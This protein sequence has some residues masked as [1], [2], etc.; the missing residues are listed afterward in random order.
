MRALSVVVLTALLTALLTV[1][2]VLASVSAA[3]A[4]TCVKPIVHRGVHNATI[5]EDTVEA[6]LASAPYGSAEIDIHVNADD[7]LVV[8]HDAT[9]DRTTDGT[10]YVSDLTLGQVRELRTTPNGSM[11]PTLRQALRAAAQVD[12]RILVELK[13]ASQWTQPLYERVNRFWHRFTARG[14]TIYV[15]GKG[16]AF[17]TRIPQWA[18]DVLVYWRPTD[19]EVP[20]VARA[21]ALGA[22]MV[23]DHLPRWSVDRVSL[24]EA[25]GFV[26]ASRVTDRLRRA[27]QLGLDFA[28][29]KHLDGA[30][31]RNR[32]SCAYVGGG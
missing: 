29:T 17:E 2:S 1:G 10:G 14:A 5:D 16:T 28:M 32:G 13:Q 12:L 15:G 18:P 26:T 4:S 30:L 9:V 23:M 7:H 25:S 3:S 19:G 31:T 20:T 24:L 8:M 22:A 27:A 21:T 11:V 6:I